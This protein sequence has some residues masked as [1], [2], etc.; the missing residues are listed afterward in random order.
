V[1]AHEALG[2]GGV[3]RAHSIKDALVE[4]PDLG[5]ELLVVDLG[6]GRR[7]SDPSFRTARCRRS[8]WVARSVQSILMHRAF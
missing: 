5:Q 7:I 3:A 4:R 8:L 2:L 6:H 1:L